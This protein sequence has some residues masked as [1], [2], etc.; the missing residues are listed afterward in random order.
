MVPGHADDAKSATSIAW[1]IGH[2]GRG[3]HVSECRI[4]AVDRH[5]SRDAIRPY[6]PDVSITFPEMATRTYRS[7]DMEGE[8]SGPN[9]LDRPSTC[10]HTGCA[11][12]N[13]QQ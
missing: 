2:D 9:T 10:H 4:T 5:T 12:W 11:Q 7:L 1:E 6:L 13:E 8:E 3:C